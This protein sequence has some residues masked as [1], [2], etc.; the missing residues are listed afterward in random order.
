MK[1]CFICGF[2]NEYRIS[3]QS[4]N[5]TRFGE[6]FIYPPISLELDVSKILSF[7]TYFH[8]VA[9]TTDGVAHGIGDNGNEQISSSLVHSLYAHYADIELRDGN[10]L[11]CSARSAVC[12]SNYTLYLI[13][14]TVKNSRNQLAYSH[15]KIEAKFPTVLNIGEVNPMSLFGGYKNCAAIDTEGG[16]IFIDKLH[17]KSSNKKIERVFLPFNEK[18]VGVA[19]CKNF[20]ISLSSNGLVFELKSGSKL[21]FEEVSELKGAKICS[22]S[23]IYDHCIAVSKDGRVFVRGKDSENAGSLGF[24]KNAK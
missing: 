4:N 11:L 6:N 21:S 17:H 8:S 20:V 5:K 18:A 23:G 7:S 24:G 19:C 22:I 13:S 2:N 3:E 10:G 1:T 14:P 9:V 15:S 12:G 16:I